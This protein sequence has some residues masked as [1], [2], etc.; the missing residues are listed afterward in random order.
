MELERATRALAAGLILG[1]NSYAAQANLFDRGGG[2]IYDDV[3]NVTWLQDANYAKTSGY[4]ADGL[5]DWTSA[6]NWAANLVYHD[7]VRNVDYSD[8]RLPT[9]RDDL[10]NTVCVYSLECGHVA[11]SE[12]RYMYT[13]NLGL[14]SILGPNGGFQPDYGIFSNGTF[15]GV[16]Q[17]SFG[18][19]SVG[20]V[21]NLQSSIYWSAD[22]YI[23]DPA[24]DP[25][26]MPNP[27][28]I[29]PFD[30]AYATRYF[31]E[32]APEQYAMYFD[33]RFGNVDV[34]EKHSLYFAWAVRPGDVA[35][36]P[37]PGAA[38][39]M[40]GALIGLLGLKRH[41]HIG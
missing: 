32:L 17:S 22:G 19:N 33:N 24:F 13:N 25:Y 1:M 11:L 39:L 10:S 6:N 34:G 5:M 9:R 2:L 41:K 26:S 20:P 29:D 37:L 14:K 30:P 4:D 28:S 31:Q 8:W 27:Y 23:E 38:W 15:N 40:G 18:Q 36:V 3:L 35:A 21:T 12:I 16:D 7:S